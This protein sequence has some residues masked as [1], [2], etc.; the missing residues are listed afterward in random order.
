MLVVA[1][2]SAV[3]EVGDVVS[4][5]LDEERSALKL[6]GDSRIESFGDG[7]EEETPFGFT[8]GEVAP[9]LTLSDTRKITRGYESK[10]RKES[11]KRHTTRT[12]SLI[13][14]R[15]SS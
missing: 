13:Q 15:P 14:S 11:H 10:E 12:V 6:R 1:C 3:V 7:E 4:E 8:G 9:D 5:A 2:D